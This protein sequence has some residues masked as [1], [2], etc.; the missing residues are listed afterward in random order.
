[1]NSKKTCLF[2]LVSCATFLT[3]AQDLTGFV[4][5]F[6]GTANG[7][8]T[9]PGAMLPWGMVS[10]SP[11][12]A[13]GSPSGYLSDRETFYGF[14]HVHLSGTGCSDLGSVIITAT[15]G[16]VHTEP[17][18]YSCTLQTQ[19]AAPGLYAATLKEPEI[20]AEATAT[21][22][23]GITR[24]TTR[25]A[26]EINILIDAGRSLNLLGGG[27]LIFRSDT[28]VDGYNVSGAFCGE[29]NR[30]AV[31]FSA[32]FDRKPSER[33]VW[34]GSRMENGPSASSRDSSIGA[35]LRFKVHTGESVMVKVGISYVNMEN[36]RQNR[37]HEIP[38]WDFEKVKWQ[39]RA[40]W[41]RELAKI[42]V[43]TAV[44]SDMV[45]FYT[46][47]YHML[48]H[49]NVISDANGDYPLM[50]RNGTGHYDGRERYTVFSLWDTYRTLHPFLTL[51]YPERQSAIVQTMID[52]YKESGWLPKWELAANETHM[53][54]G[55]PAVPVVADSWLKGITDIDSEAAYAA[56]RKSATTPGPESDPIRPGYHDDLKYGY[57]PFEQDTT[58]SWWVWGPASTTLEYCFSDWALAQMARRL[59]KDADF[60]EFSRRASFY[61]NLFDTTSQFIR[62]RRVNGSWLTPFDP[63]QTEGSGSWGGSGGPGYV[64][65]NA[66]QY[67]WFVPHDINGLAQLF[68]GGKPLVDKLAQCF[69][70]GQFT[71]N[72]EPDIAYPYLFTYFPGEESRTRTLV[73]DIMDHQ[74][75]TGASGLPGN[76]DAGAISAWFAFSAL[77]FYPACPASSEYRL[78]IPLFTR[79]VIRL[80]QT[81][82]AGEEFVISLNGTERTAG[83]VSFR[84][85]GKQHDTASI[86]HRDLV[87]G[88]DLQFTAG[89]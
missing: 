8:N 54:S 15:R 67:T 74:F 75:G 7:G 71:I 79:A 30:Q 10:V 5:P 11:H 84:L 33:G 47:L 73:R 1:M 45:K 9:F 49:P 87:A 85:N 60:Q 23:C 83:K 22:R 78:G 29:A 58:K 57:I 13:P 21:V 81:Y 89:Q 37:E 63:L 70:D 61:R 52:M 65:G 38:A 16:P 19:S 34:T 18:A 48:I 50:G 66:W 86:F 53:M 2:L 24:F 68:G 51:V 62:P 80:N 40:A 41:Q 26:G 46:A 14:G 17:E 36:A 43:E 28:E 32:Q 6:I 12:T 44:R 77:G 64:E 27:A 56:C 39:A 88:G 35:W 59:R 42:R 69:H 20:T 31:F 25:R 3:P 82:Y 72:N 55:D 76:D 4:D